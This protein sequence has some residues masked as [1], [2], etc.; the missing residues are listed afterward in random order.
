MLSVSDFQLTEQEEIDYLVSLDEMATVGWDMQKGL[1]VQV[2]PAEQYRGGDYFKVYDAVSEGSAT[3]IAR[4]NFAYPIY[5][6]HA[7]KW[8]RGKDYWY[9]NG[10]E[11]RNLI[12]FLSNSN[13]DH[14]EYT[15]WQYA[16]LE[17][18][19]GKRLSYEQTKSN[20]LSNGKLNFPNAIPYDLPMPNYLELPADER[21]NK[22]KKQE[23]ERAMAR[24]RRGR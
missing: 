11:K 6:I 13:A 14:P 10:R 22:Q 24:Q 15:N 12:E 8:N 9:L 7:P 5:T 19:K 4:I 21:A 16:I 20:L 3:R 18:N 23:I 2:N 17:F 1:L